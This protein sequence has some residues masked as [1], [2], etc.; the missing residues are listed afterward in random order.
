MLTLLQW[1]KVSLWKCRRAPG[2]Y[3]K[4]RPGKLKG[5]HEEEDDEIKEETKRGERKKKARIL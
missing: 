5:G 3:R 4:E 1:S 2:T